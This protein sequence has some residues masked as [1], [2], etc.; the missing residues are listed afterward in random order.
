MTRPL[1]GDWTDRLL[2]LL[3][4]GGSAAYFG[5]PVTQLE[6]ALQAAALADAARASDAL[7]VAALLHDIGHLLHGRGEHVAS[8]GVDAEHET[9][10][11][12]WLTAHFEPA[13]TQPVRLHVAAKRCLCAID[14]SYAAALSPAS[15]ESL[16]LQGGTM[17]AGQASRFLAQPWAADALA[18]RRWD[19]AAKLPGV[20][21]PGLSAYRSRLEA[22]RR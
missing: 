6:H 18:L 20:D 22:V 7:V 14:P 2:D 9:V 3:R 5:E 17:T 13:V 15:R 4:D 1:H 16:A 21:V 8:T 19:D 10:G 11:H 12:Q